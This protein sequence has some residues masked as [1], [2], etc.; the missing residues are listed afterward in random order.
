MDESWGIPK[1]M[2]NLSSEP[3]IEGTVITSEGPLGHAAHIEGIVGDTLYLKEANYSPCQ[4]TTR[5]LNRYDPRIR[6]F[7]N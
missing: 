4:V 6:G 3:R 1:D 5:I 7:K 2:K